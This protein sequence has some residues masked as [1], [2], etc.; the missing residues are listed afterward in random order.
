MS[1]THEVISSFLDD[2]PFDAKELADALSDPAGRAMLI[3]LVAL[4]HI[5]QPD[6]R[7]AAVR[8]EQRSRWRP[9]LA[10]AAVVIAL[11]GGYFIGENRAV[12]E[13][14]DP[15]AP[16]RVVQAPDWQPLPNGGVR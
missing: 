10:A 3:D 16:S 13:T 8:R 15:P 4:R 14:S 7:V 5:V 6:D 1:D 2:E 11:V 9:L 12:I